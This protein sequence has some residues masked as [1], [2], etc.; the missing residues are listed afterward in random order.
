MG[1]H[2]LGHRAFEGRVKMSGFVQ[3]NTCLPPDPMY[4]ATIVLGGYSS[5]SGKIHYIQDADL[6]LYMQHHLWRTLAIYASG[7]VTPSIHGLPSM[8]FQPTL[9]PS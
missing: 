2:T 7:L 4:C 6:S 9:L 3:S 8:D 5:H 1:R